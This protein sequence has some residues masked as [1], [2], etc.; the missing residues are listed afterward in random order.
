MYRKSTFNRR[1]SVKSLLIIMI[2]A[3]GLVMYSCSGS[4]TS[5]V[6]DNDSSGNGDPITDSHQICE[7]LTI[8]ADSA[9]P[10]D[11]ITVEGFSAGLGE[12]AIAWMRD[13]ENPDL[14]APIVFFI[15][16]A[17]ETA[18]FVLPVH[19]SGWMEGGETEIEFVNEDEEFVCTGFSFTVE[20]LTARPGASDELITTLEDGI[21]DLLDEMG[22]DPGNMDD[23]QSSPFYDSITPLLATMRTFSD[24]SFDNNFS[25]IIDGNAPVY[26]GEPLTDDAK[27][28]FDALI[29][30]AELSSSLSDMFSE[31]AAGTGQANKIQG[32]N[33]SAESD[34]ITPRQLATHMQV[35]QVFQA[36]REGMSRHISDFSELA[37][38]TTSITLGIAALFTGGATA[39][40]AA[41]AG[42]VG[43]M[44][45]IE[46]IMNQ[47]TADLLPS[48][49]TSVDI[50]ADPAEFAEDSEESGFW[51][52]SMTVQNRGYTLNSSALI[53]LAPS[54]KAVNNRLVREQI[55]E[56]HTLFVELFQT[57]GLGFWGA[58]DETG[59]E[60]EQRQWTVI[61]SPEREDEELFFEWEIFPLD[62]WDG[63]PAFEMFTDDD[64]DLGY[65]PLQEGTAELRFRVHPDPFGFPAGPV[66]TKEITVH[67]IEV[68]IIS[69]EVVLYMSDFEG[70]IMYVDLYASVENAENEKLE[71]DSED[72]NEGIFMIHD[73]DAHHVTYFPPEE[74]GTYL[75]LAE[76]ITETGP[77]EGRTPPRGDNIRVRVID[78]DDDQGMF[79]LQPDPGCVALDDEFTFQ[80]FMG[81]PY[82]ESMDAVE[83][84]FGDIYWDMQGPGSLTNN[85]T[86]LP[87]EKG[88]VEISF[89]YEDPFTGDTHSTSASFVVLESCGELTIQSSQFEYTTGCVSAEGDI[90][91][92]NFPTPNPRSGVYAAG[93]TGMGGADLIIGM[94]ADIRDEGNWSR[95]FD[96]YDGDHKWGIPTFFDASGDEWSQ[97]GDYYGPGVEVLE[98][99]RHE[100]TVGEHT[101]GLL[102]G[103][104]QT[105]MFNYSEYERSDMYW[106]DVPIYTVT[107]EFSGIPITGGIN[108]CQ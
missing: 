83:I 18:S 16:E 61:A 21:S 84:P 66:E 95:S 41:A 43:S 33:S 58:V 5:G 39:P 105:W 51:Q 68:E 29:G 106:S 64:G 79:F 85:G 32:S 23:Y 101:I 78:E 19:P 97:E 14:K 59:I 26:D 1:S 25:N 36:K 34:I 40:A 98:V 12:D 42:L 44:M 8:T 9:E 81:D 63:G 17:A 100:I 94:G 27:E 20:P 46:N 48:E 73:D 104:F 4:P 67:P 57:M 72:N 91:G 30:K 22:Y 92:D 3:F 15:D 74:S 10:M 52:N 75:V 96:T 31:A 93:W 47:A 2:A 7:D 37:L 69:D 99:E 62:S 77:R 70:E 86:F 54:G 102:S 82:S 107:G 13:A 49:L 80:A 88:M 103:T 89:L 108:I 56:V 45:T 87:D 55:G 65:E 38:G 53:G 60:F 35:Q 28:L 71:W 76:S 24:E 11:I 6:D 90:I 50:L